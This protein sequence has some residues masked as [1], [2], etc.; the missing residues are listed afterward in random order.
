M[1]YRL[2][3]NMKTKITM[4]YK[5]FRTY[6]KQEEWIDFEQMVRKILWSV[7]GLLSVL[8]WFIY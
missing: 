7:A 5:T 1:S 6:Q 8:V 3:E 2:L 4:N